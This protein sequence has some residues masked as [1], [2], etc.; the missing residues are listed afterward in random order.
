[1]AFKK[2]NLILRGCTGLVYIAIIVVFFLL[3][4]IGGNGRY[5]TVF[6]FLIYTFMMLYT[7]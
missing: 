5:N 3:R 7:Y 2:K 1:M 4:N 6:N